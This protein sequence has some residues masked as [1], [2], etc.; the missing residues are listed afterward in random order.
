MFSFKKKQSR[1]V[2]EIHLSPKDDN[3]TTIEN[4][5]WLTNQ[6]IKGFAVFK[7]PP[8]LEFSHSKIALRGLSSQEYFLSASPTY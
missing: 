5:S 7:L 4:G 8:D 3:G 2:A 1:G 6:N